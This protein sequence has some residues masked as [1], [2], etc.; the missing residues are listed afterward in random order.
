MV[1]PSLVSA[2]APISFMACTPCPCDDRSGHLGFVVLPSLFSCARAL[3]RASAPLT[4]LR[5]EEGG[6]EYRAYL[7]GTMVLKERAQAEVR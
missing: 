3:H 2:L 4:Q 7:I 6:F 5:N 1:S